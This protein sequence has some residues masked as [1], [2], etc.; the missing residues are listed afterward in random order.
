MDQKKQEKSTGK[1]TKLL[2]NPTT[3]TSQNKNNAF[4]SLLYFMD[5]RKLEKRKENKQVEPV[6]GKK[7]QK[8]RIRALPG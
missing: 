8:P 3:L 1:Q 2:Q 5:E 7:I 6:R 4:F